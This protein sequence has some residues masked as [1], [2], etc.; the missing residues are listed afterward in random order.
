MPLFI[1]LAIGA[2][3]G[4]AGTKEKGKEQFVAVKGRLHKD[5]TVGRP[6]IRKKA[7]SK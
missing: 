1:P 3:M 6:S 4:K 7:K 5:G 2:L